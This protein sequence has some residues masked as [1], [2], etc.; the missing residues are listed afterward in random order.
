VLLSFFWCGLGQIY[1]GQVGK[2][3]VM[4]A[5]FPPLLWI[6]ILMAFFGGLAAVGASNE[7]QAATG[8]E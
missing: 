8:V 1:N 4:M 6:G 5:F 7:N 2:G 3:I